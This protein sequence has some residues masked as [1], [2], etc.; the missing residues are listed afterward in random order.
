MTTAYLEITAACNFRCSFCPLVS[1]ERP[2]LTM[3][4]ELV[5]DLIKQ[6]GREALAEIINFHVMGEPTLHKDVAK[7]CRIATEEGLKVFLVTNG[8]RLSEAMNRALLDTELSHIVVSL[9]SP[10]D[11]YY[12]EIFKASKR[13]DYEAYL[14]QIRSLLDESCRRGVHHPTSIV[15]RVFQRSLSDALREKVPHQEAL[16]ETEPMIKQLKEWGEE[17]CGMS[18]RDLRRKY[19]ERFTGRNHIPLTPRATLVTGRIMRWWQ[20]EADLVDTKYPA[21]VSYCSGFNDQFAVLADGRVTACCLDYEG[22]T[23]LGN[24]KDHS[25]KEIL[26]GSPVSGFVRS[27]DRLRPPT[28]TCANC[29][30][31]NTL[32]EWLARQA[33]AVGRRATRQGSSAIHPKRRR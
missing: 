1:M 28:K 31:G 18:S 23:A 26:G 3:P 2:M 11:A 33:L 15:I 32:P 6:I 29:L 21:R 22:H 12:S 10:N 20:R 4:D 30:G 16:Y 5:V 7:F 13:L 19:P 27:F 9:R 17:L 25:L 24:A 14:K 8:S